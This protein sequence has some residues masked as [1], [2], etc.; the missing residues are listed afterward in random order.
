MSVTN[1][2]EIINVDDL[3]KIMS[4]SETLVMGFTVPETSNELKNVVRKFLKRKSEIFKL[5]T[6]VYMEVSES[7]RCVLNILKGSENTFPKIFH[8]RNGKDILVSV[9]AANSDTIKESFKAVEKYY[10]EEMKNFQK[11]YSEMKKIQIEENSSDSDKKNIKSSKLQQ[12]NNEKTAN[13][14]TGLTP[15]EYCE[16]KQ[17]DGDEQLDKN[18]PVLEKKI[19]LEKLVHVNKTYDEMKINLLH[20]I[21]KRKK[22]ECENNKK[23]EEDDK[24]KD[25]GTEYRK[26]RKKR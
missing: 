19:N 20:N 11:E 24:K 4:T 8:I 15:D 12:D 22:I 10:I 25:D 3:K 14:V 23:K 18:D 21:T 16:Q 17:E 5:I 2:M 7:D 26:L 6:F 1:I 13:W 9:Q